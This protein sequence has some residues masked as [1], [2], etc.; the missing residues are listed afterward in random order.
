MRRKSAF[1]TH[2]EMFKSSHIKANDFSGNPETEI[3][4]CLQPSASTSYNKERFRRGFKPV[5][6]EEG[7]YQVR[8]RSDHDQVKVELSLSEI[9]FAFLIHSHAVALQP[10]NDLIVAALKKKHSHA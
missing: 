10:L 9:A 3:K 6:M 8:S 7:V 5:K 1:C 2:A 4:L